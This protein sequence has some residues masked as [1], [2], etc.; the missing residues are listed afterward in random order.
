MPKKSEYDPEKLLQAFK[1]KEKAKI[2]VVKKRVEKRIDAFK[3]PT[4]TEWEAKK[5]KVAAAR[6]RARDA[7]P[8]KSPRVR[9]IFAKPKK[10]KKEKIL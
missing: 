6:K 9:I 3:P 2:K 7:K 10:A 1:A 4:K 5:A 8:K